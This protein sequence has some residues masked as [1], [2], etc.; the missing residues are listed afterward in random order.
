[1]EPS[2]TRWINRYDGGRLRFLPNWNA[3]LRGLATRAASARSQA[4]VNRNS[5]AAIGFSIGP[6]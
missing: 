5:G 1:M 3:G 2:V 4:R 6:R